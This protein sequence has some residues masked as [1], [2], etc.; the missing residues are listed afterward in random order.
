MTIVFETKRLILRTLSVAAA[1][2]FFEL[3]A[4]PDV[5]RHTSDIPFRSVAEAE[6]F[7][8]R[9]DHYRQ[10]DYGGWSVFLKEA[11]EYL[12]FCGLNYKSQLDENCKPSPTVGLPPSAIC[13]S[14]QLPIWLHI[15]IQ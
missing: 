3:H 9:Y 6:D 14:S 7:I 11:N 10:Y 12:G 13:E 2:G 5:I 15:Y 4:D 8:R 1:K